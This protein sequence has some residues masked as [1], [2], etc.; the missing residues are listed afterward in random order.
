M[1]SFGYL[2][3]EGVHDVAFLGKL[4]TVCWGASRVGTLE[5]LDPAPRAWM[6]AFKWP[7]P[8]GAR[9]PI[10]RLA[11]PA[12]V[13]YRLQAGTLVALRNAQG[14]T[15]I[16]RTLEI[17]LE[18]FT[19]TPGGP[20]AIGIVLDN[21]DAPA[22]ERFRKL[23]KTLQAAKL[24]V[25][26]VLGEVALGPPKVGVFTFPAPGKAG[27]LEDV[28][29]PLGEAAYPAL[30]AAA[31]GYAEQWR[32]NADGEPTV[33]DW[34][35]IKKPAGAK[36]ATIAAMTAILKP[37]RSTQASLE[38]NRWLSEQ[39]KGLPGVL[40]CVTFLRALLGS[41]EAAPESPP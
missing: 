2:L 35:E 6:G 11:V 39:T 4:L 25:P 26:S 19:R 14:L 31:R 16:G 38:D 17:D 9:T 29:L 20:D 1:T 21:D 37:G 8:R 41:A 40:P 30:S 10:D 5:E 7:M 33:S 15:E 24:G 13:F 12:P 18:A 3:T 32:K 36:K 23:E 28:L 34:R 27:T 22:D